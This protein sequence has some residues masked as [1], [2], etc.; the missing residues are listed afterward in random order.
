MKH[1]LLLIA[2]VYVTEAATAD[3]L[4]RHHTTLQSC[5]K[6]CLAEK[7]IT[8]RF[9]KFENTTGTCLLSGRD[10]PDF[11]LNGDKKMPGAAAV[12][13]KDGE[14]KIL[15]QK[16]TKV[17]GELD[18]L[19][20]LKHSMLL[21]K[22]GIDDKFAVS[23]K[24]QNGILSH[25]IKNTAALN[26]HRA[27]LSVL[28]KKIHDINAQFGWLRTFRSSLQ[29]ELIAALSGRNITKQFKYFVT[30]TNKLS[31]KQKTFEKWLKHISASNNK[32]WQAVNKVTT[33]LKI[34]KVHTLAPRVMWKL[35]KYVLGLAKR[36]RTLINNLSRVQTKLK[37]TAREGFRP[38][39]Y[40]QRQLDNTRR[41]VEKLK[42]QLSKLAGIPVATKGATSKMI[43]KVLGDLAKINKFD[44]KV[45]S[46]V[47]GV[48]N[49]LQY[50][51]RDMSK[52]AAS[53]KT[54]QTKLYVEKGLT[55]A[56]LKDAQNMM[57]IGRK[58]NKSVTVKMSPMFVQA[59]VMIHRSQQMLAGRTLRLQRGFHRLTRI[60][61]NQ[62]KI[63]QMAKI[64]LH[65]FGKSIQEKLNKSVRRIMMKTKN[66]VSKR[67][68]VNLRRQLQK[69]K[70]RVNMIYLILKKSHG[71]QMRTMSR[72]LRSFKRSSKNNRRALR[73]SKNKQKQRIVIIGRL[74]NNRVRNLQQ[75]V[76]KQRKNLRKAKAHVRNSIRFLKRKFSRML[77]R[78]N[79]SVKSKSGDRN[80]QLGMLRKH[81]QGMKVY[82]MLR[83]LKKLLRKQ[84]RS[85]NRL[86]RK[87]QQLYRKMNMKMKQRFQAERKFGKKIDKKTMQKGFRNLKRIMAKN[88]P[89]YES[90]KTLLNGHYLFIRGQL[91][92]F[93]RNL[94]QSKKSGLSQRHVLVLKKQLRN[95]KADLKRVHGQLQRKKKLGKMG[96][97]QRQLHRVN[98]R[99]Q[100]VKMQMLKKSGLSRMHVL[101]LKNQLRNVKAD[102][103]RVHGQLRR[104]TKLGQ[105]GLVQRQLNQVKARLQQVK[106][107]MLKK[108]GLNR[109]HVLVLKSQL[110]NVKAD[111][112]RVHG[113]LRRMT[114]LGQTGLVQRQLNQVKARLQQVKRKMLKLLRKQERSGNRLERKQQQLYRKT[115]RKMKQRFQAEHK[116][117]KKLNKK[118][119]QKSFR[120][121]KR[122]M[123]KNNSRF[124]SVKTNLK[125]HYLFNRR[126]L[127]NMRNL[128][129]SKKSGLNRRHVLV[130]KNQLRNVK[131]DLKRVHGQLRRMTKLGQTGLVQRQLNQVKARLQQVKREML[132]AQRKKKKTVANLTKTMKKNVNLSKKFAKLQYKILKKKNRKSN[133]NIPGIKISNIYRPGIAK[134]P[135]N[136]PGIANRPAHRPGI[137]KRPGHRPGIAKRP[138]HRPGIAN[139]PGNRP[140]MLKKS[141]STPIKGKRPVRKRR[142]GS[143]PRRPLRRPGIAKRPRNRPGIPKRPGNRPGIANRPAHRPG[144]A[145]RPGHRP[146]I[147]KR[148]GH[149]PGIAKRPGHRPGI[150]NR[151]GNRPGMLKKS[152]STP[153]KGKRP[154]RKRRPGSRPRRPLRRPGIA[155]RPRNR[156]G[157][158]KRPGN[159]PG[160]ANRPAHRPGIAKRPAHRPGIAKRPGHR[161]G[162]A[163]RP[164]NRPGMLKKSG[165]TPIKG[166]RRVRKRRPG[167][168]PRRP[169]RRPGLGKRHRYRHSRKRARRRQGRR[170]RPDIMPTSR[171]LIM[172]TRTSVV[173][174]PS[175]PDI[176]ASSRP[177]IMAPSRPVVMAP[178]RPFIMAPNR[179]DIMPPRRPIKMASRGP[180]KMAFII[181][182]MVGSS[183]MVS[184]RR[185]N[186]MAPSR[187]DI[188]AP[189][190][191]DIMPPSRPDIVSPSRPDMM[192]L[193]R[194]DMMPRQVSMPNRRNGL[195]KRSVSSHDRRSQMDEPR[196]FLKRASRVYK[197]TGSK[198]SSCP[199]LF[200][201]SNV[202]SF[203]FLTSTNH[204]TSDAANMY[205]HQ[206]HGYLVTMETKD[207]E[208]AVQDFLKR[209]RFEGERVWISSIILKEG[210]QVWE[211]NQKPV[212]LDQNKNEILPYEDS[213]SLFDVTKGAWLTVP[214][215]NLKDPTGVMYHRA[216]CEPL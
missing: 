171:P 147:A 85:G 165:S 80:K 49:H 124:E 158:P 202:G 164:G 63:A 40:I 137:A 17:Q 52:L 75:T 48:D 200:T 144:I 72:L 83:Q 205:C 102:L 155:K 38:N 84:E 47:K 162:I 196:T 189:S 211:S 176:I 193:I 157:I 186:I 79:K 132:K 87:L 192:A 185:P 42:E 14:V 174:A 160:I 125:G 117:G 25:T 126:E 54:L 29:S 166:K 76:R 178:S 30:A 67:H 198:V 187:P 58:A 148:P 214:C 73:A 7:D 23:N 68:I 140:G 39:S 55:E 120:I 11:S 16:Y 69:M 37:N 152:G 53:A 181:P 22:N 108:S 21:M 64:A 112:K 100:L 35:V 180:I 127:Q 43:R 209:N 96:P 98:A 15:L 50:L 133:K 161:P 12:P 92:N 191:P 195:R 101:V 129:Q 9:F 179:P 175:N 5:A 207:K 46:P 215:G 8:C 188:I 10:K 45:G 6:A 26:S 135:G 104:M 1:I 77:K 61:A 146:G 44:K 78:I 99:L 167:S 168:R 3:V 153:I 109:R 154:V 210:M 206:Y 173:M 56:I 115:N 199:R 159:R 106:R 123:A 172:P 33:D 82:R 139:R 107:K 4:Q 182:R 27:M 81:L 28:T 197:E 57:V 163:N 151:P 130:L 149:R 90:L 216:I 156:P 190:R 169:L 145:K 13:S 88:N 143:R 201:A 65:R 34:N 60:I 134:R 18:K 131:A 114:K 95:I 70:G 74:D 204:M 119:L 212:H 59:L 32:L 116:F 20:D 103:K 141:G 183:R 36:W 177:D 118:T 89:H 2:T 170:K 97:V 203:C 66:R 184:S 128:I 122:I 62:H 93:M 138:G 91:Q 86:E 110:R 41:D 19:K 150:A 51:V 121:F 194:S 105:T 71:K 111:L 213:C 113:Q 142:P 24:K 208:D 31:Q 136:R 94:A